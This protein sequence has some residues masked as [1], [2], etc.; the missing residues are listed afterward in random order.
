MIPQA[1]FDDDLRKGAP[2]LLFPQCAEG[3]QRPNPDGQRLAACARCHQSSCHAR[4]SD[5]VLDGGCGSRRE[6]SSNVVEN[7]AY[8]TRNPPACGNLVT[9][10]AVGILDLHGRHLTARRVPKAARTMR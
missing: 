2:S 10:G 6:R 1:R 9:R 3:G 7:L 5:Q 8:H 4:P